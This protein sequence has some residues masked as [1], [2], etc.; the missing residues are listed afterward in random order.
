M[1]IVN[2][3][4][5]RSFIIWLTIV[6]IGSIYIYTLYPQRE[7][8]FFHFIIFSI[9]AFLTIYFPI[10][11]KGKPVFLVM[12]VTVPVFLMYGIFAEIMVMQI[13]ITASLFSFKTKMPIINR[14]FFNSTLFFSLSFFAAVAF[15]FAGGE[16]G[17]MNFWQMILGVLFYQL[18][19]TILNDVALRT[20]ILYKKFESPFVR[21]ERL[22]DYYII[23][24]CIPLS[25]SL[26]FLIQI[27]G[28]TAFLLLGFPFFCIT[29][30]IRLYE[31]SEKVNVLLQQAG[32]IGSNLSVLKTE[33]E[34]IDQ[35]VLKANEM[36]SADF[37]YLFDY[38]DE[39]LKLLQACEN[40]E[41]VSL[42]VTPMKPGQGVAGS[43]L[44]KNEPI[45]YSNR[46][47]WE[48][49]SKFYTPDEMESVL[50]VPITR[51]RKIEAVLL[52]GSRKKTAFREYQLQILDLLCSYFTVS[53]EK[54]RY[55]EETVIKSERCALTKLYN[56]RS[57]EEKLTYEMERLH[58]NLT[59]SLSVIMLDIDHFKNV[60]DTYGHESGNDI[61][62]Q[63]AALLQ[64]ALPENSI[65]GRY[66]G[67]EFV[68]ILPEM[69]KSEAFCLAEQIRLHISESVFKVRPNLI[70]INNILDVSITS[71]IGVSTA[72]DDT[73][74]AMTLLRN[75][76]RA[77]YI[78]A[79]QEGRNRVAE[80]IK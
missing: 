72:P 13:A 8:S 9:L 54:S 32:E 7:I 67:E 77:L 17:S 68:V 70:K 39:L 73:D 26:Y 12:W 45:I 80:Y 31:N 29:F 63:L 4:T 25:L 56:Y 22:M 60:N 59:S 37:A 44:E 46:M 5:L 62:K 15:R 41:L 27:I 64:K 16:V 79:K 76:D 43:V 58:K 1:S 52:L 53:V 18:T 42:D 10:R 6:P 33:K 66:G 35:F 24:V 40:G 55:M 14:F 61:L 19:H 65:L 57:L 38:N 21:R 36:F 3:S 51:N 78:G 48:Q 30:L 28:P 2:S 71:S 47:E 34:V 11:R 69:Q 49:L 23:I 74:D 20:F 50:C 75:A